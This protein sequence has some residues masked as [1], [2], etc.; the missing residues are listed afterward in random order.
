[1][2]GNGELFFTA[3]GFGYESAPLKHEALSI[4]SLTAHSMDSKRIEIYREFIDARGNIVDLNKLKVGQKIYSKI[5]WRAN[6]YLYNFVI[7]EAMPSCFE[8]VNERL[9][10]AAQARVEGMQDSVA[11]E[12]T[13]YL[14]DRVLRF[15]KSGYFYYDPRDGE[16]SSG[17]I[18]TPINVI[19]AG[20]CALPAISIEDMQY[21]R[22]NNYDLQTLKFKVAR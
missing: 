3:L 1:M 20:S 19:M 21:E 13:E 7:D 9:G 6:Y 22:V 14:Y 8:A 15:P 4:Q 5:S 12:H 16:N 17:V 11:L 18:Y 10:S 2:S